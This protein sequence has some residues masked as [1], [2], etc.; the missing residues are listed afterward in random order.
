MTFA[1]VLLTGATGYVGGPLLRVLEELAA[2]ISRAI[3]RAVRVNRRPLPGVTPG[4]D[5]G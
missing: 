1:P 5:R 2:A 3:S 4:L